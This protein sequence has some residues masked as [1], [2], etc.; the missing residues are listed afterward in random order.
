M[1]RGLRLL[2][3]LVIVLMITMIVGLVALVTLLVIRLPDVTPPAPLPETIALPDG[4][5]AT[6]FTQAG[7]W[8]AVVTAADE[9]L[10]FDRE[11]G[12]LRQ[13]IAVETDR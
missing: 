1:P 12:A 3:G 6:A 9:I 7:D 5:R 11:T 4:T 2:Q 13:R 8:Y 10:I